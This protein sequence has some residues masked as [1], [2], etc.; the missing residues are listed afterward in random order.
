MKIYQET[1]GHWVLPLP[2]QDFDEVKRAR[3]MAPGLRGAMRRYPWRSFSI[4]QLLADLDVAAREGLRLIPML[5]YRTYDS[6]APSPMPAGLEKLAVTNKAGGQSALL[7]HPAVKDALLQTVATTYEA[8]RLH[9]AF[10]GLALQETAF[11]LPREV[12]KSTNYSVDAFAGVYLD[13]FREVQ[14]RS[15][16]T[17][18]RPGKRVF[19]QQNYPLDGSI[20]MVADRALAEQLTCMA[21]GGPDCWPIDSKLID[22][23]YPR[24]ELYAGKFRMFIGMSPPA[25][26]QMLPNGTRMPM[27]DVYR[28]AVDRL[29]AD[30]CFWTFGP[31]FERAA[32]V[33]RRSA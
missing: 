14:R 7:W 26:Q 10:E 12:L 4:E 19:W 20:E 2:A 32:E 16:C 29:Y 11:G 24:Y 6:D 25:Y 1:F 30:Y 33:I 27:W 9:L 5:N 3:D 13:V 21:F 15:E 31:W 8:C 17:T 28:F 23:V 18:A 22:D